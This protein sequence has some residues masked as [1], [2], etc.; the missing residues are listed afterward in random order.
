M[1]NNETK[2][3]LIDIAV[4]YFIDNQ[5]EIKDK[6]SYELLYKLFNNKVHETELVTAGTLLAC[7]TIVH[8]IPIY[9]KVN[10]ER[11]LRPF[12]DCYYG[13]VTFYK[14]NILENFVIN[15]SCKQSQ[16]DLVSQRVLPSLKFLNTN[17]DYLRAGTGKKEPDLIDCNNEIT[18]EVKTNY[19]KRGS[20]SGFHD[21]NRLVDCDGEHIVIYPILYDGSIDFS[22]NLYYFRNAIPESILTY[23]HAIS[24][25]LLEVV[26]SGELISEIE[27]R[28]AAQG[29]NWNP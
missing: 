6:V 25:E 20:V 12:S 4:K 14:A 16:I 19:R 26:K 21:A 9:D 27:Q 28:L 2:Q 23:S 15:F 22:N 18:Y 11:V 17:H 10:N 24:D 29:F 7:S 1:I 3:Q 13:L 8:N 5:D